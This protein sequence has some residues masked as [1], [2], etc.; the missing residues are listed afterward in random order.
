LAPAVGVAWLGDGAE[1]GVVDGEALG[2]L[3]GDN[4]PDEP[5]PAIANTNT[6]GHKT[7][8]RFIGSPSAFTTRA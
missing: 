3:L 1:A 7:I 5:H 4:E 2:V 8:R 6:T